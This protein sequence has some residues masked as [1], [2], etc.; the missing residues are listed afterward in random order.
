V[1]STD[2]NVSFE[3]NISE[4]ES[5]TALPAESKLS[6]FSTETDKLKENKMSVTSDGVDRRFTYGLHMSLDDVP[7]VNITDSVVHPVKNSTAVSAVDVGTADISSITINL[8]KSILI[9]LKIQV[10]VYP[11]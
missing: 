3:T 8:Q 5:Y 6:V 2:S 9:P 10:I 11:S 1:E 7:L 4:S